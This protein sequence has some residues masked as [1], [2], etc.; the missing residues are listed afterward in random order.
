VCEDACEALCKAIQ[1][2]NVDQID[3]LARQV[4]EAVRANEALLVLQKGVD[5]LGVNDKRFTD[6]TLV[7]P[8]KDG[9]P[10]EKSSIGLIRQTGEWVTT[11]ILNGTELRKA[12]IVLVMSEPA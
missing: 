4:V 10:E 1:A 7:T 6:I 11:E 12:G 5:V 8:A 9:N 2:V 3:P